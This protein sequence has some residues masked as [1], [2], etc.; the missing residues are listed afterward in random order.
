VGAGSVERVGDARYHSR[1]PR[2]DAMNVSGQDIHQA[3]EYRPTT[4][5]VRL[6]PTGL[7]LIFLGLFL[8]A[9]VDLDREPLTLVGIV[10]C[11]IT[12]LALTGFTLWRRWKH[13]KPV[14]TLSPDGIHY[15]IPFIKQVLI[16]WHEI[17]GVDTIDIE[18][19]YWSILWATESLRYNTF[20]LRDVTVVLLPKLFYEQR[21]HINS[22][23][24]RGPAWKA[25]FIPKGE[26]V[27]MALHHEYVS[28]EPRGL[29]EAVEARWLAFREKPDVTTRTSVPRVG[30]GGSNVPKTA[31]RTSAVIAMGENPKSMP[32]WE[33]T[34]IIVLLIGIAMVSTNLAG[35]WRAF[36]PTP[37]SEARAK[38]R[39]QQKVWQESI[40]KNREDSKRLEAEDKARR[41][42]LEEDMRRAFGR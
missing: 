32:W 29:R 35:L 7:L 15:R 34:K 1:D 33:A 12:G 14:F 37:E 18:A 40:R 28:V 24:L 22:F 3:L 31:V 39:E 27:Q 36:E 16:P 41:R 10:F 9:I 30:P 23:M 11:L 25:N 20:I 5:I 2:A 6:L 26:L 17:Q 8:Y 13:G 4:T 19:G 38:A 42:E 21:V